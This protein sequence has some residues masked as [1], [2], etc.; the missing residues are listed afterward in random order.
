MNSARAHVQASDGYPLILAA[1]RESTGPSPFRIQG[2]S[3]VRIQP[4]LCLQIRPC[5]GSASCFLVILL[6]LSNPHQLSLTLAPP[7]LVTN[8]SGA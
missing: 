3:S 1:E 8:T 2:P 6:C 4:R 7:R 5:Q